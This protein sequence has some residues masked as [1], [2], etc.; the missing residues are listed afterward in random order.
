MNNEQVRQAVLRIVHIKSLQEEEQMLRM[1]IIKEMKK[2]RKKKL[3]LGGPNKEDYV[4]LHES[5]MRTID[6]EALF[7]WLHDKAD[8]AGGSPKAAT[9]IF[10]KCV[11]VVNN[12]VEEVL[13][14]ADA[15]HIRSTLKTNYLS[16]SEWLSY[17]ISTDEKNQVRGIDL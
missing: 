4:C 8:D 9:N 17:K 13:G 15:D 16:E 6:P 7:V 2:R 14:R 1:N 12:K 5:E 10:L 3:D 11:S